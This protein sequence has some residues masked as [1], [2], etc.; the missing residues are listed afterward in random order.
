[1]KTLIMN[2]PK[3]KQLIHENETWKRL[4]SFMQ[5]E[6]V[7]LKTRLAEIT[8]DDS[9]NEMLEE[10]EYFQALFL[11]ED[12][13][14]SLIRQEVI[15][16]EKWLQKEIFEEG[17]LMRDVIKRQLKLRKV[18]EIAEEKFNKLKFQFNNYLS[19]KL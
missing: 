16:M 7:I 12:E 17:E 13:N 9:K 3:V 5:S 2:K 19:E 14:I 8:K 4:L 6:N 11:F 18:M 1:M 10:A 15:E